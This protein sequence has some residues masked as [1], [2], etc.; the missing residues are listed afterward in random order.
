M[1][2]SRLPDASCVP[3][4]TLRLSA[5]RKLGYQVYRD[6][7]FACWHEVDRFVSTLRGDATSW[8]S[9]AVPDHDIP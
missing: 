6:S 3:S 4:D 9:D 7:A 2:Y 5:F 8:C 1:Y